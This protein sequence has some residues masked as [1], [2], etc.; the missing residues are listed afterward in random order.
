M[1]SGYVYLGIIRNPLG[2]DVTAA[3][4]GEATPTGFAD[5]KQMVRILD[6][7]KRSSIVKMMKEKREKARKM[8]GGEG[9]TTIRRKKQAVVKG[10]KR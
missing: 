9:Q 5:E 7:K 3:F 2:C 6:D 10:K 8:F 1:K 4:R